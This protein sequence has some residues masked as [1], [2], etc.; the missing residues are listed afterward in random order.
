MSVE[1]TNI[2]PVP[3]QS[4][5][6]DT[7]PQPRRFGPTW[8]HWFEQ[9]RSK[10]NVL[11]QS[12][13]SLAGVTGAGFLVHK[14]SGWVTRTIKGTAGNISV[15]NGDGDAGDPTINLIDTAVTPGSYTSANITVDQKGR[16]TDASN[17]AGG[18]GNPLHITNVTGNYSVL[19]SDLPAASSNAGLIKGTS[20]SPIILTIQTEA[21]TS[22]PVG[23]HLFAVQGG[24]GA[25]S[26]V[27]DAGVT[28]IGPTITGGGQYARGEAIQISIDTWLISGNLAWVSGGD[29]YFS[30]VV[31]LLHFDGTSG[32]TTFTD[33]TGRPWSVIGTTTALSNVQYRF[34]TASLYV[35]NSGGGSV[36][37]GIYTTASS[38][39]NYGTGDFT[40][41]WWEFCTLL[42][43]YQT[44]YG[45]STNGAGNLV[46]QTGNGDGKYIIYVSGTALMTE[47]SPK[48]INTWQFHTLVCDAGTIRKYRDG[49]QTAFAA[50]GTSLANTSNNILGGA[51]NNYPLIGY[52]DELR[53]TKGI[54]RYPGGVTFTPPTAPFPNY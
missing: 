34:G 12:I 5:I 27:S 39:L 53:I 8:S 43:G 14:V 26:F 49:V 21:I 38:D 7:D 1:D 10:V 36:S 28:L 44:L 52:I 47:A 45:F 9:V 11:N 54:C 19:L 32:S 37:N 29:P 46:I 51:W 40:I 16:I 20:S 18:S 30:Y 6:D 50:S 48:T 13:V 23:S 35:G 33:V 41:E 17:G 15:T 31:A 4:P 25:V 42:T 22:I 2:P 3:N 24:S